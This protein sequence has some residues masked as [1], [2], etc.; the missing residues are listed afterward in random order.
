MARR[1]DRKA[2]AGF[3]ERAIRIREEAPRS[4]E[5]AAAAKA[6]ADRVRETRNALVASIAEARSGGPNERAKAER[7]D[8]EARRDQYEATL[9]LEAHPKTMAAL[10]KGLREYQ[11]DNLADLKADADLARQEFDAARQKLVVAAEEL[12]AVANRVLPR[13]DRLRAIPW[14]GVSTGQGARLSHDVGAI[15]A[16]LAAIEI[17]W[18]SDVNPETGEAINWGVERQKAIERRH[19]ESAAAFAASRAGKRA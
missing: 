2:V 17:L 13:V 8:E 5:L 1:P 19:A 9:E 6:K 18:P 12:S 7:A 16:E 11:S 15:G 4:A 14:D 10:R 3:D